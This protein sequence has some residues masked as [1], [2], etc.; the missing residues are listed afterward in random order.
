MSLS[1]S[2]IFPLFEA[3][4]GDTGVLLTMR[5]KYLK[6]HP[7]QICFPG[8]VQEKGENLLETAL[9]EWEEE[10]GTSREEIEILGEQ[11]GLDT[12]TGFHI[13]PYLGIYRGDFRFHL[14]EEVESAFPILI[15]ELWFRDFYSLNFE[16]LQNHNIFY[17]DLKEKGLLWGAT[18]ELVLRFLK[19][20]CSFDRKPIPVK[21]NLSY[22]PFFQP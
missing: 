5:S 13:T 14:N 8:G 21:P 9:R 2:V 11:E 16:G 15:S 6:S 1:S 20:F 22:P 4:D 12:R 19:E 7:G 17:F 18:C 3:K 10:M